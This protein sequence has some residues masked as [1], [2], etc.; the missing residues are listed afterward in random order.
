MII[1]NNIQIALEKQIY[2]KYYKR[3]NTLSTLCYNEHM[4][5]DTTVRVTFYL[6]YNITLIG[7]S[8]ATKDLIYNGKKVDTK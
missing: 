2:N 5:I 1:I 7:K 3:Y 4:C 8:Y 6:G